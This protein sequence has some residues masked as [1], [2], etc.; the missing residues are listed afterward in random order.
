MNKFKKGAVK[1][2]VDYFG[3]VLSK[4]SS[5]ELLLLSKDRFT[6]L[7]YQK[8]AANEII[9]SLENN[10]YQ[11]PL[12]TLRRFSAKMYQYAME[13]ETDGCN[14]FSIAYDMSQQI[15]KVF[16]DIWRE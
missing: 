5:S 10:P 3:D 12:R 6:E 11:N 4:E 8:W 1:I 2:A 14:C 7:S 16:E 13:Y 9:F 15:L